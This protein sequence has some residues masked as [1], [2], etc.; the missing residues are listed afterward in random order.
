MAQAGRLRCKAMP[1]K[2]LIRKT[3]GFIVWYFRDVDLHKCLVTVAIL[4]SWLGILGIL[5]VQ[6]VKQEL[7][8]SIGRVNPQAVRELEKQHAMDMSDQPQPQP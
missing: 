3:F 4:I 5:Y 6:Q 7:A 1:I 8:D 2:P